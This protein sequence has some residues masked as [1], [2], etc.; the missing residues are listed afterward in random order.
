MVAAAGYV[1]SLRRF[2]AMVTGII[3]T[4]NA[5]SVRLRES[6]VGITWTDLS[7]VPKPKA[8]FRV[9]VD[10][11]CCLV[12]RV[13]HRWATHFH[14]HDAWRRVLPSL[15]FLERPAVWKRVSRGRILMMFFA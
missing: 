8:T 5:D 4:W 14:L 1:R 11:Y 15:L 7:N 6:T 2:D 3:W 12:P 9:I 13:P 10:G